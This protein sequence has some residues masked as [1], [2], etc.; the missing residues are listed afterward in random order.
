M[1]RPALLEEV[2]HLPAAERLR[3]VEDVW[4]SLVAS[5]EE[6]P[7]PDWHRAEL[8]ARLAD[9]AEQATISLQQLKDRL[10]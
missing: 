4:D 2:L 9:P 8:E 3:L 5:A 1:I 7:V 10:R 6:I